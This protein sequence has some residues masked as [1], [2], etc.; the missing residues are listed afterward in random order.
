MML[1]AAKKKKKKKTPD[2]HDDEKVP[3]ELAYAY[4]GERKGKAER[5]RRM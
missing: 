4:F 1:G 2:H 3:R 5:K